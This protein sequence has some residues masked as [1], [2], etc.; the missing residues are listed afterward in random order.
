M[1]SH[2]KCRPEGS[3]RK[4]RASVRTGH[5]VTKLPP[6]RPKASRHLV[7]DASERSAIAT[8][9]PVSQSAFSTLGKQFFPYKALNVTRSVMKRLPLSRSRKQMIEFLVHF[10]RAWSGH[11]VLVLPR[12]AQSSLDNVGLCAL[13]A[14]CQ[15]AK[16]PRG[17]R[18]QSKCNRLAHVLHRK[19]SALACQGAGEL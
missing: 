16:N 3:S 19:T 14:P 18:V 6:K 7:C 9:G 12:V 8:K 15:G 17:F 2:K 1:N 13:A 4:Y 10:P 5:V 11:T